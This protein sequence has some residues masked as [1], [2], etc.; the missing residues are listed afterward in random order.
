MPSLGW[1]QFFDERRGFGVVRDVAVGDDVFVHYSELRR[2]TRGWR[3]LSRGEYVE[4]RRV[5]AARG[6]AAADVTG[7]AGG[8]FMREAAEDHEL[9]PVFDAR[10]PA[11]QA[12]S[13][14]FGR[15]CYGHV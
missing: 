10:R 7:V 15:P 11:S 8:P 2:A 12:C 13:D 9:T 5:E 14:G 4:F 1:V 3:T 6:P